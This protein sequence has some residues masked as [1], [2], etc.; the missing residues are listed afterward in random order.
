MTPD[1]NCKRCMGQGFYLHREERFYNDGSYRGN[2]WRDCDCPPGVEPHD[3][4][5]TIRIGGKE[6]RL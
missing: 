3:P 4:R 5:N 6:Y 1:P 2:D